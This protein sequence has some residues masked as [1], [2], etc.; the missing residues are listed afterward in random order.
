MRQSIV[1]SACHLLKL[2]GYQ[3]NLSQESSTADIVTGSILT[4]GNNLTIKTNI[5]SVRCLCTADNVD[6]IVY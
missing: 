4:R 3:Q 2:F 5:L 1:K 6:V